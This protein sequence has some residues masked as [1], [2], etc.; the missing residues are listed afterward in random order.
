[1]AMLRENEPHPV[2]VLA[3]VVKFSQRLLKHAARLRVEE[4]IEIERIVSHARVIARTYFALLLADPAL[5]A[6]PVLALARRGLPPTRR[7]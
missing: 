4:S 5:L 6:D 1:M 7:P 3:A 2:A